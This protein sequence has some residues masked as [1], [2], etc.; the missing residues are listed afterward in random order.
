MNLKE[1]VNL[2][3]NAV[4]QTCRWCNQMPLK[5]Q[6]CSKCDTLLCTKCIEVVREKFKLCPYCHSSFQFKNPSKK[7]LKIMYE[8]L[9]KNNKALLIESNLFSSPKYTKKKNIIFTDKSIRNIGNNAQ[10]GETTR[11]TND[12]NKGRLKVLQTDIRIEAKRKLSATEID[13]LVPKAIDVEKDS[14]MNQIKFKNKFQ[15]SSG[16]SILINHKIPSKYQSEIGNCSF[17]SSSQVNKSIN[18]TINVFNVQMNKD[19][20]ITSNSI[21]DKV[22]FEPIKKKKNN[23]RIR[24]TESRKNKCNTI[25][26]NKMMAIENIH[27][28]YICIPR[29]TLSNKNNNM[30]SKGFVFYD[31]MSK[32]KMLFLLKIV[33]FKLN[34]H[35]FEIVFLG[36]YLSKNAMYRINFK[37]NEYQSAIIGFYDKLASHSNLISLVPNF[38]CSESLK[39]F[40]FGLL[41]FEEYEKYYSSNII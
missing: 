7:I 35:D 20:Y 23:I 29:F 41:D 13:D 38:Y 37:N 5:S 39:H 34:I 14:P 10:D 15:D 24:E 8:I 17:P 27:K 11:P 1:I 12:G 28:N 16:Q 32:D 2:P 25:Q 9:E 21:D 40:N 3:K 31:E 36:T 4:I 22:I 6:V 18:N 26:S 30:Y 33:T 19:K